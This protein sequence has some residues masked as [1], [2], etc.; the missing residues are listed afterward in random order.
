MQKNSFIC[1]VDGM[2]PVRISNYC[3]TVDILP[4]VL[5]LLG[6]T[7]DSR[8]MAG[9]DILAEN[10]EHAAILSDGSF[11]GNGYSYDASRAYFEYDH[12]VPQS[13]ERAA[14]IYYSLEK[15]FMVSA[16][17]LNNNYYSYVYG[18]SSTGNQIDDPTLQY[19]DVEIM[20][21]GAVY[22]IIINDIMDPY[23]SDEFGLN[24]GILVAEMLDAFYRVAKRPAVSQV[25]VSM[26]TFDP[27]YTDAVKWAYSEGIITGDDVVAND[28]NSCLEVGSSCVF[29]TRLSKLMGEDVTVDESAVQTALATYPELSEEYIRSAIFC[30]NNEIVSGDGTP[31]YVFLNYKTTVNKFFGVNAVFKLCTYLLEK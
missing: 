9:Q 11:I 3:S 13:E 7:Y 1:Y 2:E 29:I 20:T 17:I 31:E 27:K 10:V 23:S 15:R 14:D 8:L 4:T 19:K 6:Y 22:Y 24:R 25:D 26:F 5:N 21:Q 18:A 16:Q 30:K 12:S 28:L